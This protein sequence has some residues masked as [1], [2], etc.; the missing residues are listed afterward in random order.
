M[1]APATSKYFDAQSSQTKHLIGQLRNNSKM[2]YYFFTKLPSLLW[3]GIRIKSCT[4]LKTEITIPFGWRTQNPY[5]SIYFAAQAGAGEFATG[6]LCLIAMQG[7]KDISMLVVKQEAVFTKKASS[8]TTFTCEDGQA[9]I[10]IMQKALETGEGHTLTMT[11]IGRN[12]EGE[13]VSQVRITWSFKKR[14]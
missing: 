5:K 1:S 7:R 12:A 2:R 9:V 8:R 10:D 13:E 6:M 3:W 14:S 4:H 11:S